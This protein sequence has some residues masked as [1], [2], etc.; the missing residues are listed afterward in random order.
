MSALKNLGIVLLIVVF[1]CTPVSAKQDKAKGKNTTETV[2]EQSGSPQKAKEK[3][4]KARETVSEP[5]GTPDNTK[6]KGKKPAA[7]DTDKNDSP[8][9][10][11]AKWL[12]ITTEEQD[13]LRQ[14][15][16]VI[17]A[18]PS[19]GQTANLPPGLAK[20]VAR[21]KPL[22]PGWQNKLARGQAMP[23]DVYEHAQLLPVAVLKNLP[24]QPPGTILVKVE[25]KVVR[26]AEA[27]RTVLDVFDLV[28]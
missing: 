11:K 12:D 28:P 8:K 9:S 23:Q 2:V 24:P 3:G 7:G 20:N 13:V 18:P 14:Q 10:A 25:G 4:K 26:L 27:T 6:A 15:S 19:A 17:L 1:A 21:G 5:S 22:P 16:G